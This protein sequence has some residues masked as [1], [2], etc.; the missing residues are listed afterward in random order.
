M[1]EQES[2]ALLSASS[3]VR[4]SYRDEDAYVL[5]PE[6][7]ERHFL[8]ETLL[9]GIGGALVSAFLRGLSASVE[10]A[11]EQWGR[12][13]GTWIIERTKSLVEADDPVLTVMTDDLRPALARSAELATDSDD[14]RRSKDFLEKALIGCGMTK[15]VAQAA[16]AAA[17]EEG[18][19][20]RTSAV[21]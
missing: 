5:L 19:R 1:D 14:E 11:A 9:I 21:A 16:A 4:R 20:L 12:D 3:V 18:S 15:R 17:A 6:S 2:S 7:D 8:A 13:L 10:G